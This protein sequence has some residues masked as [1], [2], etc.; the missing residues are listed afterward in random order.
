MIVCRKVIVQR[1]RGERVWVKE[2][3]DNES[4]NV[5][6]APGMR[7]GGLTLIE[8]AP[9]RNYRR[10][11]RCVCDC[12]KECVVEEYHLKIG[13]TKSCGC[14]RVQHG[15][16][17]AINLTG[18]RFGRLTAVEATEQRSKNSVIWRCRCD[19]GEEVLC[20]AD[21]LKSGN[22]RSCGCLQ[23]EQRKKNM[24]KAIHFVDGTCIERI[25]CQ[26]EY[27][28]NT[29]GHRG[30][31]RRKNGKWR[32]SIEFRGKRYN[33]GTFATFEEAVAARKEGEKMYQDFLEAYYAE[34]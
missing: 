15:R 16:N 18:M 11:W 14:L 9:S 34:N 6:F 33:L 29:S 8:E 19:C 20:S 12:G 24:E 30:V 3:A 4:G 2:T 25:A 21:S 7:F 28:T 10:Y 22:V 27:V 23:A 32:A 5:T 26:R 13:H 1:M 31:Y 17:Q